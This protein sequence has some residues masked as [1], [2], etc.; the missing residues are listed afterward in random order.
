MEML[1]IK[2]FWNFYFWLLNNTNSAKSKTE[3]LGRKNGCKIPI[4]G[5]S[6]GGILGFLSFSLCQISSSYFFYAFQ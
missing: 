4:I 6:T 1:T 3:L 5:G 2:M